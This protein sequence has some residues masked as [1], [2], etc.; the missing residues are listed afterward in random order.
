MENLG[1]GR[2]LN[3]GKILKKHGYSES[4]SK[5]PKIVTGTKAYKEAIRPL[6]EELEIQRTLAIKHMTKTVRKAKYRDL[7]DALDKLTKNIQ[8]LNGGDTERDSRHDET[9]RNLNETLA[10]LKNQSV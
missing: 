7:V 6:V 1:K 8:L 9:I 4:V 5:T 3:M 10:R 2:K